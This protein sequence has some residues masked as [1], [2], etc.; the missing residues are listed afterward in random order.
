M[1]KNTIGWEHQSRLFPSPSLTAVESHRACIRN[2]LFSPF[3]F[4][5]FGNTGWYVDTGI[6]QPMDTQE[7]QPPGVEDGVQVPPFGIRAEYDLQ[8][9]LVRIGFYGRRTNTLVNQPIT[10]DTIRIVESR[11][12]VYQTLITHVGVLHLMCAGQSNQALSA[13]PHDHPL[14]VLL[15]PLFRGVNRNLYEIQASLTSFSGAISSFL[16]TGAKGQVGLQTAIGTLER[17]Q[18]YYVHDILQHPRTRLQQM[19]MRECPARD[20]LH[21]AG[22][23]YD[24]LLDFSHTFVDQ[25]NIVETDPV[26]MQWKA[27]I[28]WAQNM[29]VAQ[30]VTTLSFANMIHATVDSDRTLA[31]TTRVALCIVY[32]PDGS[33][34]LPGSRIATANFTGLLM[35]TQ[36]SGYT[37]A[38]LDA[39][40]RAGDQY[41]TNFRRFCRLLRDEESRGMF[42]CSELLPSVIETSLSY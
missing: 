3:T 37:Y 40:Y 26:V 41:H 33:S 28:G 19:G 15:A 42:R 5:T 30:I 38:T 21:D 11:L 2:G 31:L 16:G 32:G 20:M 25:H 29:T 22:R 13:I 39:D 14:R 17:N 23:W 34:V 27:E 1:L 9:T 6:L 12:L 8:F 35:Y 10:P 4:S 7:T 36:A 18:N 24:H